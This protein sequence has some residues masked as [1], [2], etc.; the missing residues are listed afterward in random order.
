[1]EVT[2]M[3]MRKILEMKNIHLHLHQRMGRVGG[4]KMTATTR[5]LNPHMMVKAREKRGMAVEV[6]W[7]TLRIL[8]GSGEGTLAG[9]SRVL[10]QLPPMFCT[11]TLS[12]KMTLLLVDSL[13]MGTVKLLS[14]TRPSRSM[15]H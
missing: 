1:M 12:M 10:L 6:V 15:L 9:S 13:H 3:R 5:R 14:M 2:T 7:V 4:S 11:W 8:S